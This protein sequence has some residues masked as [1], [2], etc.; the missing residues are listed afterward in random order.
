V[1]HIYKSFSCSIFKLKSINNSSFFFTAQWAQMSARQRVELLTQAYTAAHQMAKLNPTF[2][3][4]ARQLF[5][6]MERTKIGTHLEEETPIAVPAAAA[7][8]GAGAQMPV[9]LWSEL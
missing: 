5:L 7:A 4:R 9:S 8:G 2:A 6:G 3:D 1:G